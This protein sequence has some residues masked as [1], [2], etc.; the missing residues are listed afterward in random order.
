MKTERLKENDQSLCEGAVLVGLSVSERSAAKSD[1]GKVSQEGHQA[2]FD[3]MTN[4]SV[5][6]C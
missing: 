5:E 1:V 6:A 3:F 4:T 2:L